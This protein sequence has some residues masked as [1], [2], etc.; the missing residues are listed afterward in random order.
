MAL[1]LTT[2]DTVDFQLGPA[3]YTPP[4]AHEIVVR[5]RATAVNF[6][7]AITGPALREILP[8]LTYPAVVGSDVAGDV[9]EIGAGVTRF[10]VGDRVVGHAMG[11]EESR[12]RAAEGAFQRY[13][14]LMESM[15]AAI[16][17]SLS[18]AD[19]AVFPMSIS[20]A[21]TG[22]FQH[23]HLALAMPTPKPVDQ[24]ATV[25]VW[26]GSSSVGSNAIQ[27]ARHAGYKVITTC[28]PRNF[29]YVKFLGA[30]EAFDYNTSTVVNMIV[31]AIDAHLLA[32]TL[33]IG[34]GALDKA[35]E[36]ASRTAG[37]KR[38]AHVLPGET[39]RHG[40]VVVTGIWGNSLKDN[41]VGSA[42]YNDF[43]PHGLA[44]RTYRSAP[45]TRIV[46]DGLAAIPQALLQLQG[47]VSAAKLVV[48]V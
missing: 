39:T 41:E 32:G 38:V 2:P 31:E 33:A 29:N 28:S 4:S 27:L 47:G 11:I 19:A 1:W 42:I 13:V 15:T 5:Q 16:P 22:L 20:T 26:G 12:N 23:D 46:G 17:D 18:F 8:W 14:V 37:S 44:S 3:P 25:L 45:P 48:T 7:D 30:A 35:V 6:I 10:A 34:T 9:V 21:A 24:R 40:D 36:I 43:L